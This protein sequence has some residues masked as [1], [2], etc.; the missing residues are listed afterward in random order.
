[1]ERDGYKKH[2]QQRSSQIPLKVYGVDADFTPFK[3]LVDRVFNTI[4]DRSCVRRPKPLPLN[5]KSPEAG[6]Y[7]AFH[8]GMGYRTIDCR[9]LRK[10]L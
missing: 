5:L 7:C 1:M 3:I 2:S 4:Q 10:Q 6:D 9:S 8:Y